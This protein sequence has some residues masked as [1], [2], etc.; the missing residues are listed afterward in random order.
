[1]EK[2]NF[3]ENLTA[4]HE[5]FGK[6][7]VFINLSHAAKYCGIDPRT[8]LA[9]RTFPRKKMQRNCI[10]QPI[11]RCEILRNRPKNP[12]GGQNVSA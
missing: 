11:A 7:T 2:E 5:R 12:I 8:L 9:D 1:M 4:L 10:H 3:H 6:E